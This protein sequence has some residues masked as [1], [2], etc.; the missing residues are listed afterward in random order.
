[1]LERKGEQQHNLFKQ[2]QLNVKEKFNNLFKRQALKTRLLRSET[3]SSFMDVDDDENY[4]SMKSQKDTITLTEL[5]E[6]KRQAFDYLHDMKDKRK[7]KFNRFAL[8]VIK[9]TKNLLE[10]DLFEK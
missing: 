1:M 7:I 5:Q 3:E 4:I 10:F 2:L 6:I 9:L 8:S